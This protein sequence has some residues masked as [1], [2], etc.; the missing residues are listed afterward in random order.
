MSSPRKRARASTSS[1]AGFVTVRQ[2]VR[3]KL[4]YS[5][6]LLV[7]LLVACA[8]PSPSRSTTGAAPSSVS[9]GVE[10]PR[11]QKRITV[12]IRGTSQV[13]INKLNIGNSG[14]G[15]VEVEKLV[16]AA[17]GVQDDVDRLHPILAEAIPTLEN[18]LW[19]VHPD[20][21][22]ETTWRL[23][24]GARWHDGTPVTTADLRF[25]ATVARDREV[26]VFVDRTFEA[27]ERLDV[28]DDRTLTVTWSRPFVQ[29]D[30]LLAFAGAGAQSNLPP[31]P[32]HL[33]EQA[34]LQDKTN[35][36][37]HAY[38]TADFVG[39]GPFRLKEYDR[40]SHMVVVANEAFV[41]GRPKV[42]EIEIKFIPDANTIIANLLAGSLDL[43]FDPR[44]I[45][46]AQALQIKD[47]W[48]AGDMIFARMIWVTMYPQ[49]LNPTPAAV[50][51]LRFRRALIHAVDRQEIVDSMQAGVGGVAHHYI[52]PD[53][54]E[55]REIEPALVKY[56]YDPRRATQLIESIGFAKGPDGVY[57]DPGG[58]RFSVEIR[59]TQVDINS[60]SSFTVAD[61]WQ[62]FGVPTDVA[63]VPPQRT[64]E[65]EYRSTYPGFELIR[66]NSTITSF[67]TLKGSE[68]PLPETNWA[69]AN[70]SR[71]RNAELDGLIE[72]YFLTIPT[73]DRMQV[74]TEIVHHMTDQLVIMGVVYDP[75]L[76]LVANRVKNV[77]AGVPSNAHE[78]DVAN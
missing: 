37:Q 40:D 45:S 42:D 67:E 23:R 57:R 76:R 43:T 48:R 35:L 70:R 12:G 54:A 18:G 66:P 15:V 25:T 69:G 73:R 1:R 31:L 52:G 44:S 59:T 56:D 10:R 75:P 24:Q 27:I 63:I 74:L 9:G 47:Q 60:K 22:M 68:S 36:H 51:D 77:P 11:D 17:L 61:Y 14:L 7:F 72:R 78:W 29:A 49:F 71:Y 3:W 4:R 28:I 21:R 2:K 39:A 41:L 46:F 19:V 64:N 5:S 55:Y 62:R 32:A 20:G 58:Q 8:A 38:W 16:H 53:W 30:T 34:Y 33:L 50:A 13:L 65:R 6:G 26:P